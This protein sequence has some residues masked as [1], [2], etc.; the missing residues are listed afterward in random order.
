MEPS[1]IELANLEVERAFPSILLIMLLML[2]PAEEHR[3]RFA[4][5]SEVAKTLRFGLKGTSPRHLLYVAS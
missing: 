2:T 3:T 5:L 1:F 4:G